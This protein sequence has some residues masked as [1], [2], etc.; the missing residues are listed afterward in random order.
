MR[1]RRFPAAFA[2]MMAAFLV[3]AAHFTVVYGV[4]GLAC[5]R[6]LDRL[7][8]LGFPFVPFAVAA[9]TAVALLLAAGVL[10]RALLGGGPAPHAQG[11]AR[12]F[13]RWFTAAAAGAAL[14]AILW[15]GLPALQVP[16]CG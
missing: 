7:A 12:R 9:A 2:G 8:V 1:T 10:V 6:G 16:A 14:I 13:L 3:W 4:N 11:D 5:A 15:N